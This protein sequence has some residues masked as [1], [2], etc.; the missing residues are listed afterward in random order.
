MKQRFTIAVAALALVATA[1][2]AAGLPALG[3]RFQQLPGGRGKAQVEAACSRCHSADI[4]V[5]QRLTPKQW[6]ATVDKMTR[7]GAQL[8]EADKPAALTYLSSHFGPGNTRFT[9]IHVESRKQRAE[10]RNR[11][12]KQNKN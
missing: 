4:I 7:W 6:A 11:N 10:S 2:T 9:P 3:T 12:Q 5:Q 8:S 1:A